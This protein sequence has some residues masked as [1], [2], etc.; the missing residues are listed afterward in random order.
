MWYNSAYI[1]MSSVKYFQGKY[2]R[3]LKGCCVRSLA[4]WY[5][6]ILK[7]DCVNIKKLIDVKSNLKYY[8]G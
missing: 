1:N 8:F 2:H 7:I 3:K 6:S 5:N 4:A